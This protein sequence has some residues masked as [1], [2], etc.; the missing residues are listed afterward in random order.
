MFFLQ[1][2]H[3]VSGEEQFI[4]CLNGGC[5]EKEQDKAIYMYFKDLKDD[6]IR[7]YAIEGYDFNVHMNDEFGTGELVYVDMNYRLDS[8]D[9]D[10]AFSNLD[11]LYES[12]LNAKEDILKFD[13][14]SNIELRVSFNFRYQSLEFD[15]VF[16]KTKVSENEFLII[17]MTQYQETLDDFMMNVIEYLPLLFSYHEY[18][19]VH[20][21]LITDH[22]AILLRTTPDSDTLTLSMGAVYQVDSAREFKAMIKAYIDEAL[23]DYFVI[24]VES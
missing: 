12:F 11:E 10:Q 22:A 18:M 24:H 21:S 4:Y 20:L 3:R 23:G 5:S 17:Y 13:K 2:C 1:G 9:Y 14:R 7:D 15:V 6:Q 16:A 19:E 8:Y